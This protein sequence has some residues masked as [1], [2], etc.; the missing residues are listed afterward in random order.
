MTDDKTTTDDKGKAALDQV[1]AELRIAK[2]QVA[3]L[4]KANTDSEGDANS[5]VAALEIK[6]A[7]STAVSK[8]GLSED[9]ASK[10]RGSPEEILAD[11]EHWSERLTNGDDD[12]SKSQDN[13]PGK[14]KAV[15]QS[16][17]HQRP[18]VKPTPKKSSLSWMEEYKQATPKRREEMQRDFA[19]RNLRPD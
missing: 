4:T 3:D 16:A 1:S 15:D 8:F 12:S 10:L 2:K 6:L 5:R 18:D 11:A 7:R 14:Q 17:S 9:D 13:K 19:N